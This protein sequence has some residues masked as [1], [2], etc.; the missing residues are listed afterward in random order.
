MTLNITNVTQHRASLCQD[1]LVASILKT[2][3]SFEFPKAWRNA[4]VVPRKTSLGVKMS[5]LARGSVWG[6]TTG[7]HAFAFVMQS[8]SVLKDAL[9]DMHCNL[10]YILR[11]RVNS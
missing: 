3:L 4:K 9:Q 6:D 1:T 2:S 10:V 7:M 8:A 11:W 5:K